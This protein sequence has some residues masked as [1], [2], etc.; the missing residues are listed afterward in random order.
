[1]KYISGRDDSRIFEI[2]LNLDFRDK[3]ACINAHPEKNEVKIEKKKSYN[4]APLPDPFY[5]NPWVKIVTSGRSKWKVR[6]FTVVNHNE[7]YANVTLAFE[8][9]CVEKIRFPF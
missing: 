7:T 2:D 1:M 5:K 9:W 8:R 3:G 4:P 6:E